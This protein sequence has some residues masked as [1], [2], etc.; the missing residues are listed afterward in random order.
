MGRK[1]FIEPFEEATT[2]QGLQHFIHQLCRT[3]YHWTS[4]LLKKLCFQVQHMV[5]YWPQSVTGGTPGLIWENIL[6]A[7]WPPESPI[8]GCLVFPSRASVSR[9]FSPAGVW[10]VWASVVAA[11]ASPGTIC[12]EEQAVCIRVLLHLLNLLPPRWLTTWLPPA[13]RRTLT[14]LHFGK[15]IPP[16]LSKGYSAMPAGHSDQTGGL[17]V[18]TDLKSWC[19]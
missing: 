14:P 13:F 11:W 1:D 19:W 8:Q 4:C 17:S 12:Q 2:H 16:H 7:S 18:T 3:M 15:A 10:P 9:S 6:Q 5:G